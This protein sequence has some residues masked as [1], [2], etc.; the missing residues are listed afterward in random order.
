MFLFPSSN[1]LFR[2]SLNNCLQTS[3]LQI[4]SFLQL[5]DISVYINKNE[6]VEVMLVSPG[7]Q[8]RDETNPVQ[9]IFQKFTQMWLAFENLFL[10]HWLST[11]Q[12]TQ[13]VIEILT[14]LIAFHQPHLNELKEWNRN[15]CQKYIFSNNCH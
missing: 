3:F 8:D 10:C 6:N 9:I 11:V 2:V 7:T 4:Q 1:Q 12:L 14:F 13:L 5:V 15:F